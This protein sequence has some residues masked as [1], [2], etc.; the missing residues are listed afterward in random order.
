MGEQ[1]LAMMNG[2]SKH[3]ARLGNFLEV[4]GQVS[5]EVQKQSECSF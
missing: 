3:N 1:G 5:F 4:L 2:W